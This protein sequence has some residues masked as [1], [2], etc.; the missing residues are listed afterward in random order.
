VSPTFA[1]LHVWRVDG[2]TEPTGSAV[3]VSNHISH[4]DPVLLSVVFSRAI[5]WM[6]TEEFYSHSLGGAWL[7]ALNTF[8][9]DRTRPD[10]RA[11]RLGLARLHSKRLIGVFPEGGI[12]AGPTSILGGAAP[13]SG[14]VALARLAEV[15]ILPC[16]IFGSDRLYAHRN[17]IPLRHRVPIWVTVGKS[18][19]PVGGGNAVAN[20][21]LTS[22]LREL[23]AAAIAHFNL[24]SDDLPASPQHRKGR[25]A[26]LTNQ[27]A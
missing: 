7:R 19:L 11:L 8:P 17:W 4:F 24:A 9:V 1:R 3:L 10:R 21:C 20:Q 18:F 27:S 13:K 14:A 15:P 16:V 5:D 6:T 25:D 23:G 22:A 12:R 2:A 26:D